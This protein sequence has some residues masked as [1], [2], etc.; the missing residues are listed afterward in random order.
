LEVTLRKLP[1]KV[2][3][4]VGG[5][6]VLAGLSFL[7][8][9][10]VTPSQDSSYLKNITEAGLAADFPTQDEAVSWGRNVCWK[11]KSGEP[12]QGE[13]AEFFAVEAFC[14][15]LADDFKLLQKFKV[16]GELKFEES[17]GDVSVYGN[18]CSVDSFSS[19]TPLSLY[20]DGKML[21]EV[22]LGK[23]EWFEPQ[24]QFQLPYCLFRFSLNAIEGQS[25]YKLIIGYSGSL[26]FTEAELK[27]QYL[28]LGYK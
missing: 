11:I 5:V 18:N 16:L 24:D 14:P 23:G 13:Q 28:R 10:V 15:E 21:D 12:N 6:I 2:F 7:A 20:G 4:L 3:F 25:E 27:G 19:G 9:A 1:K 22:S 8:I 26:S 17:D